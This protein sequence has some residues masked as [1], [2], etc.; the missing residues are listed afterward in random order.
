MS[1]KFQLPS[2]LFTDVSKAG[3]ELTLEEGQGF[4]LI[5]ES[6]EED[7]TVAVDIPGVTVTVPKQGID[8]VWAVGNALVFTLEGDLVAVAVNPD[9]VAATTESLKEDAPVAKAATPR[10]GAGAR[11]QGCAKGNKLEDASF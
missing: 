9:F 4:A 7:V 1:N 8:G 6:R 3:F 10:K 2:A 11:A 5:T